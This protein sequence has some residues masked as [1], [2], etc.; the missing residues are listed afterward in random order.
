[1]PS[2]GSKFPPGLLR[3]P[4]FDAQGNISLAWQK[5]LQTQ[6]ATQ[7]TTGVPNFTDSEI[8]RGTI[9]GNNA[10][11]TLVN[12]PNPGSSLQLYKNGQKLTQGTAFNLAGNIITYV[13]AYV[14]QPG[15]NH[16]AIYR[17]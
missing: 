3:T 16:E 14:P 15:D 13:T 12:A 1:M 6:G 11:F 10:V 7:G 4:F 5:W 17:H 8:P 2:P 9:D